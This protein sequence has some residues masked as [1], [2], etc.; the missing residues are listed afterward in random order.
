MVVPM[1]TG[2]APAQ[3]IYDKAAAMILPGIWKLA[4]MWFCYAKVIRFSTGLSCIF[5]CGCATGLTLRLFPASTACPACAAAQVH[6][7][8]ARS[9]RLTIL[10]GPLDDDTL[11]ANVANAEAVA[12]MK[13]GRHLPRIRALL[14]RLGLLENRSIRATPR[15]HS[16]RHLH[17]QMPPMTLPI[18]P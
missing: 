3:E 11:A 6:P 10:P 4:A 7:L 15:C 1:R 13:V 12:I 2:R 16:S 14:T 18:F 5:W 8:V 9:D 17:L